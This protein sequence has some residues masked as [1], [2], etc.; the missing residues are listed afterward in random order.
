MAGLDGLDVHAHACHDLHTIGKRECDAFLGS[1]DDVC[2]L[3]DV[4]VDAVDACSA[5]DVLE[6]ALG[7]IAEWD[8]A[9]TFGSYGNAFGQVVH[10]AI[11]DAFWSNGTLHPSIEDAR[12]VD[13]KEHAQTG[14]RLVVVDMCKSIDTAK[15]IVVDFAEHTI[16]NARCA[17]GSSYFAWF[18]HVERKGIVWL[19]AA[20]ITNRSALGQTEFVGNGFADTALYGEC[21]NDF[22][23]E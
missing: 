8:D 5:I 6:H 11:A 2:L 1:T 14:V 9:E 3:V 17:T 16:D 23:D 7:T 21:G 15:R 20:T 22:G 18:H 10:L 12:A 19:V 13:A 4:E